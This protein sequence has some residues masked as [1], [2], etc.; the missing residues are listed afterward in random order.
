MPTRQEYQN[1]QDRAAAYSAE[2]ISRIRTQLIEN[3]ALADALVGQLESVLDA[4]QLADAAQP[5]PADGGLA[6]LV[7]LGTEA[8]ARL[9]ETRHPYGVVSYDESTA[10]DRFIA[11][12]D[13]Y[14]IYQME[15]L[16][17][18]RAILKLQEAFK[19]GTMRFSTGLGAHRL[20]QY[21]R[22]QVLRSTQLERLQTYKRVFGYTNAP[23]P[24]TAQPNRHFHNLFSNFNWQVSQFF[25]DKRVSEV[26]RPRATDPSFG[27]IAIVR[28]AGLD[29]RNNLKNASYGNVSAMSVEL[30][31]LL[32]EAFEILNA[33]DIRSQ[34]GSDNAW[35]TLEEVIRRLLGQHYVPAS[36]RSR[37]AEAARHIIQWLAQ[38]HI[39]N[40][41]RVEFEA[42]LTQIATDSEEWLT[43][44]Q[45]LPTN[46]QDASPVTVSASP[47]PPYGSTRPMMSRPTVSRPVQM[48]Q[49]KPKPQREWQPEFD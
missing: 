41:T 19:A 30:M 9:G 22:K 28:R 4:A 17:V 7:G 32:H 34:F 6:Q 12:G 40:D 14:Y 29:L 21:D 15:A 27:S 35:D 25:R 44:A 23:P 3:P 18:F 11:A 48:R 26:I 39:L 43:S 16:G 10:S 13:L 49:P 8:S 1:L 37:M 36:Q 5:T 45:A 47:V 38:P 33:P 2:V 24:T 20:Y 31:Q 46:H 42:L